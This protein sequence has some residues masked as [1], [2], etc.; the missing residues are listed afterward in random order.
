[1]GG[2]LP[3]YRGTRD[4]WKHVHRTIGQ[5]ILRL[6]TGDL[7]LSFIRLSSDLMDSHPKVKT[8]RALIP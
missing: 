2:T 1:M 4:C 6:T 8:W 7:R 3:L 5:P